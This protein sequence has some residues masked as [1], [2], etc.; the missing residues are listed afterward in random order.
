MYVLEWSHLFSKLSVLSNHLT[1]K[2][3]LFKRVC[4]LVMHA[5]LSFK[6]GIIFG[7]ATDN[8]SYNLSISISVTSGSIIPWLMSTVICCADRHINRLWIV[9]TDGLETYFI[10]NKC[11]MT[12]RKV[13]EILYGDI[14]HHFNIRG[15]KIKPKQDPSQTFQK[16]E[17][18]IH[19]MSTD[20]KLVVPRKTHQLSLLAGWDKKGI[21]V[22][23][24]KNIAEGQRIKWCTRPWEESASCL[25]VL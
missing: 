11:W 3:I 5:H 18:C 19:Q 1:K 15:N 24:G 4:G 17:H 13:T 22:S 23:E 6:L 9:A 2:K 7:Y 14:I 21:F 25:L 20:M 12:E 8:K 10:V 16:W